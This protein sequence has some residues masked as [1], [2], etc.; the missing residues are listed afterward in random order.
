MSNRGLLIVVSG[1]S[2]AGKGTLTKKLIAEHDNYAFSVSATTRNKREGEQDGKDYF[3]VS[4]EEFRRMIDEHALIEYNC[5]VGSYYGTPREPVLKMME[6]GKDVILEIDVNGARNVKK[7]YPQ[8]VTFFV[9]APSAKALSDRLKGRGT[10]SPEV[11]SERL[12]QTVRESDCIKDYDYL[13]INDDLCETAARLHR[14]IC[15]QHMRGSCSVSFAED[16]KKEMTQ[17]LKGD[18]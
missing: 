4:Q 9:S 10:E 14:I 1:F 16:F 13:I 15:D 11:V 7:E 18:N 17:I 8:A 2:G 5:Y 3:F 12:S 6:E